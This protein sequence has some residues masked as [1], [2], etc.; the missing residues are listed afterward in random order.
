MRDLRAETYYRMGGT[1][2]YFA[3]PR[4]VREMRDALLWAQ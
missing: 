3:L 4:S 1:A 2:R